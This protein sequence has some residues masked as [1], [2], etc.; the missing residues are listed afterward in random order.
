MTPQQIGLIL[1]LTLLIFLVSALIAWWFGQLPLQRR[2]ESRTEQR[3]TP[4]REG[5]E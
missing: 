4:E 2:P 3:Y 5:K 1:L